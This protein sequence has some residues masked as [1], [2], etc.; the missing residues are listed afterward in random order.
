MR[1]SHKCKKRRDD[2]Q[3]RWRSYRYTVRHFFDHRE[4]NLR[5]TRARAASWEK[6]SYP[7]LLS[8]V[9]HLHLI[10]TVAF[11]SFSSSLIE[12]SF[13]W[14]SICYRRDSTSAHFLW[15]LSSHSPAVH[16][17]LFCHMLCLAKSPTSTAWRLDGYPTT[18]VGPF[19]FYPS[20]LRVTFQRQWTLVSL[21]W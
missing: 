9:S 8:S 5:L 10:L 2:I 19:S 17:L 20:H 7:R 4:E 1:E 11:L 13:L 21:S 12:W 6:S 15:L 18:I 16:F 14:L 3:E